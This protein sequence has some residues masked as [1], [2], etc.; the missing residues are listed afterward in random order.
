MGV[1]VTPTNEF[2]PYNLKFLKT[3]IAVIRKSYSFLPP[4]LPLEKPRHYRTDG[5]WE[6]RTDKFNDEEKSQVALVVH[7][8][9]V[10]VWFV[11]YCDANGMPQVELTHRGS[12]SNAVDSL[13]GNAKEA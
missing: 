9:D 3:V 8:P 5:W 10:G 1:K 11:F 12:E 2:G 4:D 6:W 13:K 7:A